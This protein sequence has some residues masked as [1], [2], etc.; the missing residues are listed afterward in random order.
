MEDPKLIHEKLKRIDGINDLAFE[1]LFDNYLKLDLKGSKKLID[2]ESTDQES[3]VNR[4]K[5]G[6]PA[7]GMV[8]T[9]IHLNETNI[10][11]L[12]NLKTGKVITFHDFTPILFCTRYDYSNKLVKG[13]NL[14]MLPKGERVKFF[15]AYYDLYKPFLKDIERDT[16]YNVLALNAEYQIAAITGKNPAIFKMFNDQQN[17]LFNY[18][19]RSY[20]LN[21]IRKLRM[22][23]YE[24]WQ[25]IPFFDSKQSFKKANL[26]MIYRTYW[27]NLNKT[28]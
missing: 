2:I 25:Y 13:I 14:N 6:V 28:K 7:E 22:I 27:N 16:E 12:Q 24:E 10:N 8:Y 17:A 3:I 26:E 23:E 4:V 5:R 1:R 11:E 20:S 18:G 19:Y 21:H 9:F 15:Q